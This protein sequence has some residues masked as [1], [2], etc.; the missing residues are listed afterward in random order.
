VA[1]LGSIGIRQDITL[2]VG[3]TIN[4][5]VEL[6]DDANA[7]LDLTGS[8]FDGGISL[9]EDENDVQQNFTFTVAN[10]L[11]GVVNVKIVDTST[12]QA[13]DFL[14]AGQKYA[15]KIRWTDSI[16]QKKTLYYGYIKTAEGTLP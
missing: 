6:R 9:V 14:S 13:D 8:S 12:L 1:D 10:P 11:L 7:L 3:D 2:R 15:Y 4:F 5:D 16:G